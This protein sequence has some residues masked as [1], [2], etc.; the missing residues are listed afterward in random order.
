[1]SS[2]SVESDTAGDDGTGKKILTMGDDDE[3]IQTQEE[4]DIMSEGTRI[5][6]LLQEEIDAASTPVENGF[7]G[8]IYKQT[9]EDNESESGSLQP[10]IRGPG[11]PAESL[12]SGIDETPSI[13]VCS[14]GPIE[15]A[16]LMR[17]IRARYYHLLEAV[18]YPLR[19]QDHTL[20]VQL[21]LFVLSTVVFS[22]VW[23]PLPSAH[24]GP[25]LQLFLPVI[26]GRLPLL[27]I[28]F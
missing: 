19:L 24:L 20:E 5:V 9:Q 8:N 4:P 12:V 1:M 15:R 3:A 16:L 28:L 11:S 17:P 26:R 10:T 14:S 2:S 6:E 27:A 21:H 23:P 7:G 22:H 18:F 25:H 13:Q